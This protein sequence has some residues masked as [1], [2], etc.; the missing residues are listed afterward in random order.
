MHLESDTADFTPRFFFTE[1]WEPISVRRGDALGLRALT[2]L[3]AEAVAPEL[4]NRIRDGRWVT[5]LAWCLVRSHELFLASGSTSLSTAAQQRERYA[6]LQ[7]LELMWVARTI[8]LAGDWSKRSLAGSRSVNAWR[9]VRKSDSFGMTPGQLR[10]YRQTGIYGGYRLGFRMWPGMTVGGDGWTPGPQAYA[11]AKWLDKQ[12]GTA[13]PS[14]KDRNYEHYTGSAKRAN[15]AARQSNWWLTH[16]R[17]FEERG[18]RTYEN[19]LPR[20]KADFHK[21][22]ESELLCQ[23]IFGDDQNGKHRRKVAKAVYAA[24]V[25]D[26]IEVC[27]RLSQVFSS[28]RLVAVLPQFTRLADA[29]MEVMD[30]IGAELHGKLRIEF[31]ILAE[32]PALK[33]ACRELSDAAI[34]WLGSEWPEC[35]HIDTA[36][37]FADAVKSAQ[38][39]ECL[40]NLLEYHQ[41]FGGGLRWFVLSGDGFVELRSTL[42]SQSSRYRFRLW[43]LCRLA[44]QCGVIP[45]MPKALLA[46]NEDNEQLEVADE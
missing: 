4:S 24:R 31:S 22:P 21:V 14:P 35:P 13:Q 17:N 37:R 11:L 7:P 18:T 9:S 27:K 8:T 28:N 15:S 38:P 41:N 45:K 26:H 2:D 43:S 6:W 39:S 25:D 34:E 36:K 19:T 20:L 44:S 40:Q 10:S 42:G 3:F 16:W 32:Q 29:G 23:I 1:P 33:N 5:I 12:L 46:E 30:L